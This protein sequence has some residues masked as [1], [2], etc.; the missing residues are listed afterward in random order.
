MLLAKIK[1]K[2]ATYKLKIKDKLK[3][4]SGRINIFLAF[5]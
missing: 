1:L 5:I 2:R 3:I 4:I